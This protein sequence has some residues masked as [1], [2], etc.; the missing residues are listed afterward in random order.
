MCDLADIGWFGGAVN[1]DHNLERPTETALYFPYMSVP[2]SAWFTQVLLYWDR[3]GVIVPDGRDVIHDPYTE[4]LR[5][6]DMLEY[7]SP[8]ATVL[9]GDKDLREPFLELLGR[10]TP[11][12]A[13]L[14]TY[15]N[16]HID[17]MS[18]GIFV[19]L[20]QRQLA[21]RSAKGEQWWSIETATAQQYM[22]Y[23]AS[24]MSGAR[25]GTLPVTDQEEA[26]A[27]LSAGPV[28]T[29]TSIARLRHTTI[30]RALPTPAASIPAREIAEF[31]EANREQLRRCRTYLDAKLADLAL[32]AD[33]DVR[34]VRGDLV[35]QEIGDEVELLAEQMA[36]RRWPSVDLGSFSG[37]A[38]P[39]ATAV[40]DPLLTGGS[41]LSVGLAVG[42]GLY[43]L[44]T[45][46][47]QSRA[48]RVAA[49]R[50][51]RRS[52]LAYAALAGRQFSPRAKR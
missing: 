31:K 6:F 44:A 30:T 1:Q 7:L 18:R 37:T 9:A 48:Q 39:T 35:L 49:Q 17:K 40:A 24:A 15:T 25:P 20:E 5:E 22:S 27:L 11:T 52:P 21:Q 50:F 34:E 45:V 14:R 32:V 42:A 47:Y 33:P 2:Q 12:P 26:L 13:H 51:N 19:E 23:L 10:M 36:R 16:I 4:E 29:R 41:A 38:V 8:Q 3:V 46:A 28:D 43:G